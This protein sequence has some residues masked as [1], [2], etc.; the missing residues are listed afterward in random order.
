M[1]DD[2]KVSEDR[3]ARL[4]PRSEVS[5]RPTTPSRPPYLELLFEDRGFQTVTLQV[6]PGSERIALGIFDG[7]AGVLIKSGTLHELPR[8]RLR[9]KV[10]LEDAA[11][12]K[13]LA[14]ESG[15]PT[16]E[17]WSK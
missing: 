17:K 15:I 14:I 16:T 4:V 3:K 6:D 8:W 9:A 11:R 7:I 5:A 2:E 12:I 13:K 10:S 1:N